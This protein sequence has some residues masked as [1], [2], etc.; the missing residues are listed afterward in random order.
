MLKKLIAVALALVIAVPAFAFSVDKVSKSV[1]PI[2]YD[3]HNGCTATSINQRLGYWLTA[4]HCIPKDEPSTVVA[5]GGKP[6]TIVDHDEVLDLAVVQGPRAKALRLQPFPPSIG[7]KVYVF[8]HPVGYSTPQLFQ[9]YVASI[10]LPFTWDGIEYRWMMFDMTV[11]GGNS[12]SAV[13]NSHH[14]IVSVVQINHGR[15]CDGFSGG[16]PWLDLILFA[17]KYVG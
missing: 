10:F 15:P 11:C 7:E 16:S 1:L 17:A 2:T 12:G 9:G 8:G 5:I 4:A 6:I 3:G 13:L 14:E